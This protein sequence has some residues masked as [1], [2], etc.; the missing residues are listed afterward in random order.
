MSIQTVGLAE[1]KTQLSALLDAVE[2][3]GSAVP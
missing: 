3:G 1:A 2:S